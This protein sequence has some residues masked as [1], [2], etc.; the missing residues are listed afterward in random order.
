MKNTFIPLSIAF[1]N[2][3]WRVIRIMDMPVAPD[4]MADD[5]RKFPIYDPHRPYRYALEVNQGFFAQHQIP[6]NA[7][8]RF[9]QETSRTIP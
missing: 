3:D 1:I 9:T 2:A 8:V 4:P 6:E 7:E 5:A